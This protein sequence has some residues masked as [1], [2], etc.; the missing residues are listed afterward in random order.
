VREG[1]VLKFL[2]TVVFKIR[3][4]LTKAQIK[5]IERKRKGEDPIIWE[6][7]VITQDDLEWAGMRRLNTCTWCILRTCS[8]L[9]SICRAKIE[10]PTAA[11]RD[12]P[13]F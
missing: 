1:K 5:E 9:R 8:T 2:E 13:L 7:P 3:K 4:P 6:E 12:F 10:S 11:R